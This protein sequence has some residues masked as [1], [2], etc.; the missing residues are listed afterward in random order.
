M[1]ESYPVATATRYSAAAQ[2]TLRVLGTEQI[3]QRFARGNPQR[4]FAQLPIRYFSPCPAFEQ[5]FSDPRI[6]TLR[7][8]R[9]QR[10]CSRLFARHPG[11]AQP[12]AVRGSR[13]GLGVVR[14]HRCQVQA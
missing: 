1:L 8:N 3:A 11:N 6:E 7:A 14:C 9:R 12:I 5:R 10:V 13:L 2:R 4:A